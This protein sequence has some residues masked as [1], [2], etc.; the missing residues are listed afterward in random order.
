MRA[1]TTTKKAPHHKQCF[2]LFVCFVDYQIPLQL[3]RENPC[4]SVAKKTPLIRGSSVAK[5]HRS[6][7]VPTARDWSAAAGWDTIRSP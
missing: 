1:Y 4:S 7:L 6:A 5:N 2:V 3:I